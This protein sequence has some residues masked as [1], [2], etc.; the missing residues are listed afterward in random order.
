MIKKIKIPVE[1]SA[2]HIHLSQ[3]DLDILFGKKYFLK[4]L[5]DLSQTGEFATKEKVFSVKNKNYYFRIIGPVRKESQIELSYTDS[6]KLNINIDLRLSGDLK[7]IKNFIEIKGPKGKVKIKVIIAKRHL[8]CSTDEAKKLKLKNNQKASIKIIGER[9]LVFENIIVRVGE[10][11][12]LS[13][14][15]DTDEANACGLGK[16]CGTGFLIK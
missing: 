1:V 12:N 5:K 3:K 7:N 11:Y 13:C 15:V 8:H 14:H 16:V 6:V 2:R 9:G 4:K 10:K